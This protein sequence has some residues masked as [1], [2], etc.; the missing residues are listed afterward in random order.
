MTFYESG[1]RMKTFSIACLT[2]FFGLLAHAA[3]MPP[4]TD[5]DT[6]LQKARALIAQKDW[7]SAVPVLDSYVKSHPQSADGFNLLGY[8]LRNQNKYDQALAA[9]QQ[10]LTI[11]PKH[12]GAH[13]YMGIA[14]V[15]LGQMN[16]AKQHLNALDKICTFSCEEYSDL[17]KAIET[18]AR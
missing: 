4:S 13:E 11:D 9:Y 7:T 18:A 16:K 6:G 12:K 3:D 5:A 17:K 1:H 2:L 8:S 10:A 14:Y 15:Q